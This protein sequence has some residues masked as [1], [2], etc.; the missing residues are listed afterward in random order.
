MVENFTTDKFFYYKGDILYVSRNVPSE[1][2]ASDVTIVIFYL[3]QFTFVTL[4]SAT[5]NSDG[6][7][8][9]I[10]Q[11]GGSTRPT[12]RIYPIQVTS[13]ENSMEKSIEYLAF[14]TT[15]SELTLEPT[16]ESHFT[17]EPIHES[18]QE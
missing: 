17:P 7:F 2:D 10:I 4:D 15:T 6:N 5:A 9:T 8:S 12:Y 14:S 1:L 11:V 13:E 3:D 18:T 16:P